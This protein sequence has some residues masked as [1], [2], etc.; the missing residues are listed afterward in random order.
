[1]VKIFFAGLIA[2]GGVLVLSA[3]DIATYRVGD[4]AE[5][6]V[7]TPVAMDVIDPVSTALLKE[8]EKLKTPAIFRD[9]AAS[10]TNATATEFLNAFAA[11]R[12]SFTAALLNTFH[13][14]PLDEAAISSPEFGNLLAN[15]QG[16]SF[17]VPAEL[18]TLWARGDAGLELRNKWLD[19]LL[20]PMRS[21]VRAGDLPD[22]FVVNDL[23]RLVPVSSPEEAPALDAAEQS[24][25]LVAKN[26]LTTLAKIQVAFRGGF[27]D[28]Q[29]PLARALS[30]FLKPTCAPDVAL[31][32]QARDRA[33]RPFYVVDHYE[34]GQIIVHRGAPI[35]VKTKV[36]LEQLH[37]KLQPVE[38]KYQIEVERERALQQS[39]HDRDATASLQNLALRASARNDW[40]TAGLAVLSVITLV[41]IWQAGIQRR[42][43]TSLALARTSESPSSQ[44]DIA[45]HLAQAV[46]EALLQELAA[47]R[48]ELL[49]AQQSAA[50]EVSKL[51]RRLDELQL[52]LPQ[53]LS[54]GEAPVK[55]L[56]NEETTYQVAG[57]AAAPAQLEHKNGQN[58]ATLSAEKQEEPVP[59]D[60]AGLLAEGQAFLD[61]NEPE[62][63]LK[64][65][66]TIL[67]AQPEHAETLIKKGGALERI[68][69]LD[70][71]VA[72]YD[73][74]IAADGTMTI[75]YLHKGGLFNRM[76]RYDEAMACYEKAL[77]T[78]VKNPA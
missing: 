20:Q 64:C 23:L 29:Q 75:A 9:F 5:L 39:Q 16:K 18:E 11:T 45:V 17:P 72:S 21:P 60:V 57:Q 66:D 22:G 38:L 78:Q 54:S 14:S 1:M 47:Q 50:N 77:R 10:A 44:S 31:T 40:L 52:P 33:V 68:G 43:A 70:E 36:A 62:K 3:K 67:A 48:V 42:R 19:M 2:L 58:G 8:T 41:A 71:A 15:F 69:R 27:A 46:K 53:R 7:T 51:V 74:A 37:E 55:R 28:G 63:A 49:K 59:V 6:D 24:G 26:S 25:A 13:E 73:R 76:A 34:P 35:D 61:D 65:F 32:Q 4:T 30:A 56:G 12:A